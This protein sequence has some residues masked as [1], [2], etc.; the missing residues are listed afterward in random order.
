MSLV[1]LFEIKFFEKVG[2]SKSAVWNRAFWKVKYL[3]KIVKIFLKKKKKTEYLASTYK[4][5][6]FSDKLPK[7]T[8]YI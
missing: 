2:I 3:V 7:R 5:G 1:Q 4:S 6:G 8:M